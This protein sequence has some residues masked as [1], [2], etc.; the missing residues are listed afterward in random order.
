M[1]V[2]FQTQEKVSFSELNIREKLNLYFIGVNYLEPINEVYLIYKEN[3]HMK[4]PFNTGG[5]FFDDKHYIRVFF[6]KNDCKNYNTPLLKQGIITDLNSN[7]S[8]FNYITCSGK[9]G[10]HQIPNIDTFKFKY[11]YTRNG[12]KGLF[13][14]LLYYM[15]SQ[16]IEINYCFTPNFADSHWYNEIYKK[17]KIYPDAIDTNHLNQIK[18]I[19]KSWGK[20]KCAKFLLEHNFMNLDIYFDFDDNNKY[21]SSDFADLNQEYGSLAVNYKSYLDYTSK[22]WF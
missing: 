9:Y 17:I 18:K 4:M 8:Y 10:N 14:L 7:N 19:P 2:K 21:K 6:S 16:S 15:T 5:G 11:Q 22:K 12:F 13:K 20:K 3:P 1:G